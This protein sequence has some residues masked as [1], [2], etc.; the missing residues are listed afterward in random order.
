MVNYI[1]PATV[2]MMVCNIPCGVKNGLHD[3]A[4]M[5]VRRAEDAMLWYYG[6]YQTYE[7]AASA[8]IEI[9]NGFVVQLVEK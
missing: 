6:V 4:F 7:E 9:G 3:G 8:A 2:E 5:V 1:Y